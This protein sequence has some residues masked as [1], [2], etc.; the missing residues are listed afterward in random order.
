MA[1]LIVRDTSLLN[2][3]M[4]IIIIDLCSFLCTWKTVN[5]FLQIWGWCL[6]P[7]HG[8]SDYEK[9]YTQ[10]SYYQ[11]IGVR[12]L[13]WNEKCTPFVVNWN[14]I[15]VVIFFVLCIGKKAVVYVWD[16]KK[17][18]WMKGISS[19]RDIIIETFLHVFY[20]CGSN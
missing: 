2:Y 17:T 13:L 8:F 5:P 10:F 9:E 1:I 15:W 14:P 11:A 6:G 7:A 19:T 3:F 12:S 18:L 16:K 20:F 4:F